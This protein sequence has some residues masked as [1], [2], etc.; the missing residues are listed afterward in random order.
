MELKKSLLKRDN[1]CIS[2]QNQ[3]N[4]ELPLKTAKGKKPELEGHIHKQIP[5]GTTYKI[6]PV[7]INIKDRKDS[8][9]T[10]Y[11]NFCVRIALNHLKK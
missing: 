10:R 7:K 4:H 6:Y 1:S 5:G 3:A 8:M 9:L 11:T 2:S